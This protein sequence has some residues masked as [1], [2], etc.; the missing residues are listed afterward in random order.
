MTD[1][2][3]TGYMSDGDIIAWLQEKSDDQYTKL[4]D[5]MGASSER[6]QIMKGLADLGATADEN[7]SAN[8]NVDSIQKF[9]DAHAGS[10]E[11]KDYSEKLIKWQI[12]MLPATNEL[13][14]AEMI[15]QNIDTAPL[16]DAQKADL[17][18]ALNSALDPDNAEASTLANDGQTYTNFANDMKNTT[19]DL[20]RVDQLGLIQIQQ[21]VSD[22]K[23]TDQ[24][25]SNILSSRDQ[26]SN[27]IVGN[28]RG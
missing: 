15:A 7:H 14:D 20:G 27:A 4:R 24:M 16:S 28:I 22:A 2:G 23:Q 3:P 6:G 9:L 8:V 25:A 21:L 12:T 19:D 26:A 1:I 11:A 13:G 5:Q 10:P 17:H 18:A